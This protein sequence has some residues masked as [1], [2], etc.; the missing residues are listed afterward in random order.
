M[1]K[2][3]PREATRMSSGSLA[4]FWNIYLSTYL[5]RTRLMTMS[6]PASAKSR[7][8]ARSWGL[9]REDWML[10]TTMAQIS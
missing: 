3:H 10:S 1:R 8:I 6:S 7:K 2:H 4:I 5:L 9:A